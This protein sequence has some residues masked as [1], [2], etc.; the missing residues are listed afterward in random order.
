M[1]T[2]ASVDRIKGKQAK[3]AILLLQSTQTECD[4]LNGP[5]TEFG[6]T[7]FS[8]T[9][10]K[11]GMKIYRDRDPEVIILSAVVSGGSAFDFCRSI[12]K[13]MKDSKIP[14]IL[15]STM[16]SGRL[17][18]EIKSKWG[19]TDT[20]LLPVTLNKMFHLI[21]FHLGQEDTRPDMTMK[22]T[23]KLG[24]PAQPKQKKKLN[25]EGDLS[26]VKLEKLLRL[27]AVN[28]RSGVLKLKRNG[29][30]IDL[31]IQNGKL[32]YVSSDYIEGSTLADH[33][34]E[35]GKIS[36]DRLPALQKRMETEN[37][38]LGHLLLDVGLL[39]KDILQ[40]EI[41]EHMVKK[42][43]LLFDWKDGSYQ[44]SEDA[45]Q[46]PQDVNIQ[47][48]LAQVIF[49]GIRKTVDIDDFESKIGDLPGS[50]FKLLRDKGIDI[51]DLDLSTEEKRLAYS[52]DGK[53]PLADTMSTSALSPEEICRFI[54]GLLALKIVRLM[55]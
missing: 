39:A 40:A 27:M 43:L 31:H 10:Y 47:L 9:T 44:L 18:I 28:N 13:E 12:R 23:S 32:V 1:V 17:L 42:A 26:E 24:V 30:A 37:K 5:L 49:D 45:P 21:Q 7:V 52:F 46:A 4:Q 3:G 54:A 2:P 29:S 20:V 51:K 35:S 38:L 14:I 53:Q 15:T 36:P 33:L 11:D 34:V 48:D 16:L 22:Q 50:I 41:S 25:R 6:F 19:V 55:K 8:A